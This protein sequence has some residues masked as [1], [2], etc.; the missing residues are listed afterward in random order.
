[1]NS[2]FDFFSKTSLADFNFELGFFF[3]YGLLIS[4]TV[5]IIVILIANKYYKKGNPNVDPNN[6]KNILLIIAHPDDEAM[7][8]LLLNYKKI[9]KFKIL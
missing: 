7:Y 8:K 2:L 1:M 3:K 9:Q 4:N 5:I 6:K